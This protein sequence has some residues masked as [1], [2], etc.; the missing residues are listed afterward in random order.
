MRKFLAFILI[1]ALAVPVMAQSSLWSRIQGKESLAHIKAMAAA[2]M[3]PIRE[4]IY[5]VDPL[6][7][8]ANGSG[9]SPSEAMNNIDTA[10][11]AC[12]DSTGA[13]I[14][15][16]SNGRTIAS[17]TSK[18]THPIAWAKWSITVLGDAAPTMFSQRSRI[19]SGDAL[20]GDTLAYLI[21]VT[22]SNNAFY[23]L[24]LVNEGDSSSAV[25]AL[26]IEGNRNYFY[27][28]HAFGAVGTGAAA[29]ANAKSL[30]LNGGAENTFEHCVFG[31]N[32]RDRTSAS[33]TAEVW[34]DGACYRNVF[35]DCMVYMYTDDA[36]HG[37]IKVV[38]AQAINNVTL[39]KNCTFINFYANA[40]MQA[41]TALVIGTAPTT[42]VIVLQDP[43]ICGWA[44]IAASAWDRVV[45][46]KPA[47]HATGGV[48]THP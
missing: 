43:C 31:S 12:P 11:H 35:N 14:V 40:G 47:S 19:G 42:G 34:L 6:N 13:T 36:D 48:C 32:T 38:D 1:L 23:N 28:V 17:N 2:S 45:T 29:T 44:A 15:I 39:F 3:V 21:N 26:Q 41:L 30:Y 8:N 9:L 7:G 4:P 24:H 5:Y 37:A 27:N 10:Y 33:A 20:G 25:G 16:L 22:G 18:L 46:N